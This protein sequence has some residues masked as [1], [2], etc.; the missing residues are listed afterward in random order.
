[1][2]E[3]HLVEL[4]GLLDL[5]RGLEA[6]LQ[7]ARAPIQ[8]RARHRIALLV[9]GPEP[10]EHVGGDEGVAL[11]VGPPAP[12]PVRVLEVDQFL[13]PHPQLEGQLLLQFW[14]RD[15][16]PIQGPHGHQV[17]QEAAH[18]LLRALVGEVGQV[19]QAIQHA[20][21]Q[22]RLQGDL[23]LAVL[24][25]LLGQVD[26]LQAALRRRHTRGGHHLRRLVADHGQLHAHRVLQVPSHS[27]VGDHHPA[28]LG[29]HLDELV[30]ASLAAGVKA[31][32]G[33]P[34]GLLRIPGE[35]GRAF[36]RQGHVHL[37]QGLVRG[38]ADQGA[39]L[40]PIPP[41]EETGQGRPDEEIL[42]GDDLVAG[43]PHP[44]V[45]ADGSD[46]Q[47][48]G[49][50]VVRQGD[51]EAHLAQFIGD[52]VRLPVGHV[53]E[54]A[55]QLQQAAT[56]A[57]T[58]A[59]SALRQLL[60]EPVL[61]DDQERPS[62]HAQGRPAVEALQQGGIV[63]DG[64]A[65][66]RFVDEGRAQLH[67]GRRLPSLVRHREQVA[68]HVPRLE[69]GRFWPLQQLAGRVHHLDLDGQLP[70]AGIHRQLHVAHAHGRGGVGLVHALHQDHAHVDVGDMLL[71][72]GDLQGL[73]VALQHLDP[74][75]QDAAALQGHQGVD[76]PAE[77]AGRQHFGRL[78]GPVEVLVPDQ[79]QPVVVLPPPGNEAPRIPGLDPDEDSALDGV[80]GLVLSG[81]G[82]QVLTAL[83][84]RPGEEP[85]ALRVR[86][87]AGGEDRGAL[88]SGGP[89]VGAVRGLLIDAVPDHLVHH[90]LQGHVR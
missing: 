86:G 75:L 66:H 72:D 36:H 71:G 51:G 45:V 56:A 57:A 54:V 24:R 30:E 17:G 9:R 58:A 74:A 10:P 59:F 8:H 28:G 73:A 43:V 29:I 82:D 12:A 13:Q 89:V 31:Q 2:H 26:H 18:R 19:V 1:M 77:G 20:R 87:Q 27:G 42:G 38:V 78:P 44:G 22:A 84:G 68:H 67:V 47:A 6:A 79:L 35:E 34:L 7:E 63:A 50:Q 49:G 39:D 48:P 40:G 61:V 11:A 70:L 4:P 16:Q 80:A 25:G 62:V 37:S 81:R 90:Q 53:R 55:A 69:A 14:I 52:Q 33:G 46:H 60:V 23:Q 64:Q 21:G 32:L 41:G 88:H 83:L 5:V 3:G 85:H 15:A 76:R 65:E